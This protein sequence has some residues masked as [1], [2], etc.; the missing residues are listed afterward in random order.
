MM[1]RTAKGKEARLYFLECERRSLQ[2]GGLVELR[3][4]VRG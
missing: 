3:E 1:E 2:V 4:E